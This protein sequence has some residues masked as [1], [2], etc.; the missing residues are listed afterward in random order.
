MGTK[1]RYAVVGPVYPFRGGISQFTS[2]FVETLGKKSD[3][4]C[5][6]FQKQYPSLIFPGQSQYDRSNVF[7]QVPNERILTPYNPLTFGKTAKRILDFE[8]EQVFFSYW[9][10]FTAYAYGMISR[11]IKK[12]SNNIVI[13]TIAHNLESHEKWAFGDKLT[14]YAMKY[15][16]SIITL[17]ESVYNI[18][19]KL[20]PEKDIILGFHPTYSYY[21]NNRFTK[22]EAKEKMGLEGKRVILF[23][24]YIKPYKGLDIL[25][26]SL[27][28]VLEQMPDVHLLIV[29]EVY[30]NSRLYYDLIDEL[31]LNDHVTFRRQF[32]P[33]EQVEIF[34]KASDVLALPYIH[35]TQSGV[36]QIGFNMGLGAVVT[37]VGGLP[38]II[39]D[40]E[41]GIVAHSTLPEDF[42]LAL[43]AFFRLGKKNIIER[44]GKENRKY[45]W[46]VFAELVT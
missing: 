26:K 46:D 38:E 31:N 5:I 11:K 2:H 9:I 7:L 18:G 13:K 15:S 34:F 35:A 22:K 28:Y 19:L 25:I 41:T 44:A 17:S 16:D 14:H 6:N 20:F 29:G 37:P 1:K 42:A 3:I 12:R 39:T 36:A 8:P 27:P 23:F 4:L 10:P 24:G 33:N 21:N 30:G 43:K 40:K 32:V 45:S